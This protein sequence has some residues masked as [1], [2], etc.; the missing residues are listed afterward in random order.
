M[1]ASSMVPD[2]KLL[3]RPGRMAPASAASP[4][5]SLNSATIGAKARAA[6]AG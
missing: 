5:I 2:R 3:R 6:S 4:R 1:M